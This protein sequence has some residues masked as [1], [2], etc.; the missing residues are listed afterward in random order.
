MTPL[1]ASGIL[2]FAAAC[3]GLGNV[4]QKTVLE[5]VGPFTAVGI[6]SLIG[7]LILLPFALNENRRF[8]KAER[9]DLMVVFSVALSFTAAVVLYQSAFAGTSVTNAGFLVNTCTAMTPVMA[10]LMLRAVPPPLM[11]PAVAF[12]LGGIFLMAGGRLDVF[13]FGDGLAT[14][15]AL[16]YAIWAVLV[17]VYLSRQERPL[18]LVTA[19]ML[20]C[21]AISLCLA[22][23]FEP[24]NTAG[25]W[26]ALPQ[27]LFLGV[28]ATA[29][30]YALQIFAQ[31][32]VSASAAMIL[33]SAEAVFGAV[34]ARFWLG[35]TL[36]F[37]GWIGALLVAGGIFLAASPG[38]A[39]RYRLLRFLRRMPKA[40]VP[41]PAGI[42]EKARFL[43]LKPLPQQRS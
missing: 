36:T 19:S 15:A 8:R 24:V 38:S 41:A 30:P 21:S 23:L 32:Y 22:A 3:W 5:E 10:W 35:E 26:A 29:I 20:C 25:I 4:V 17:G 6:R 33:V 1:R 12:S 7:L 34:L 31:Q 13:R 11:L 2:L 42:D 9:T 16:G 18:F 39:K 40:F 27:L 14:L 37:I 43:P 28:I